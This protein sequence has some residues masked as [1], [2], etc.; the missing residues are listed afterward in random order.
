MAEIALG[1]EIFVAEIPVRWGDQD[2]QA[3][4]NNVAYFRY[5]EETRIQWMRH[6]RPV[7]IGAPVVVTAAATFLKPIVYPATLHITLEI[8]AVG[9][10]SVTVAHRMLD[11]ADLNCCYA[12]GQVK[13]VWVDPDAGRSLPLPEQV[14]R[15]A[16]GI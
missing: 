2:P 6:L 16:P 4:V 5:L 7:S 9:E 15:L 12:E 13:L 11:A 10:R 1:K 14:R 8:V 3:H